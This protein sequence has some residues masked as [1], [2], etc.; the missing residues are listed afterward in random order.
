M[1]ER[2]VPIS[3]SVSPLPL[4][5]MTTRRRGASRRT[6][7]ARPVARLV[8]LDLAADAGIVGVLDQLSDADLFAG[9]EVLLA[10]TFSKPGKCKVN[11]W[12]SVIRPSPEEEFT[13]ENA[14]SA[15]ERHEE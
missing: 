2:Y 10:S 11:R 13:A 4:S 14:E 7:M 3:S 9:V 15:E 6:S 12:R 1:V 8:A 5:V